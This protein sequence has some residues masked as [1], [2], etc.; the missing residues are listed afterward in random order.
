MVLGK[1]KDVVRSW[2]TILL[3]SKKP[4]D[5]EFKLITKL[6]FLGFVLIGLIAYFIHLVFVIIG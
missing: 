2:R 4:D 6:T 1:L 5:E 3:L